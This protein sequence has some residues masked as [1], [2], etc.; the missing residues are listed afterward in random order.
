[1]DL[2]AIL[3]S[4]KSARHIRVE[5]AKTYGAGAGEIDEVLKSGPE[6]VVFSGRFQGA[7]AVFK[8][9]LTPDAVQKLDETE[10]EL[11]YLSGVFPDG[12]VRAV[13]FLGVLPESRTLVIGRAPGERASLVLK[14]D[15][16]AA[17]SRAVALCGDWLATVAALR[18]ETRPLWARRIAGQIAE[19][20]RR[21]PAEHA[22]LFDAT[23]ERMA[24]L[25]MKHQRAPLTHAIAHGDFAPVNLNIDG[26]TVWGFDI[27]GG[28]YMPLARMAARFLV[29]GCLYWPSAPGP[30]GLDADDLAAFD[31]KR[32]LPVEEQ[33]DIFTFFVAEQMLRQVQGH[34]R[35]GPA[36]ETAILRLQALH[37]QLPAKGIAT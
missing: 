29:A 3:S 14:T 7:P 31:I 21:L 35:T 25:G 13:P 18:Q 4:G 6:A 8:Q 20:A 24:A 30:L 33:G 16:R 11:S 37:D 5:L 17:R 34:G 27:Q 10:Q 28:H 26:D 9:L 1:M 36:L 15:D 12:P 2:G 19:E 23:L 32:I 22:Q